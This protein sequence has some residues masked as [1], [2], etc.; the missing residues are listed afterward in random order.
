MHH[1]GRFEIQTLMQV[2]AVHGVQG[3]DWETRRASVRV[4][5]GGSEPW[6]MGKC[7]QA[8]V[9]RRRYGGSWFGPWAFR[10]DYVFPPLGPE[11]GPDIVPT[12]NRGCKFLQI[13]PL[14]REEHG[15]SPNAWVHLVTGPSNR[16]LG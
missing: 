1:V 8:G 2:L 6:L 4:M 13:I 3:P 16:V 10:P 14:H 5:S 7:E 12:A 9:Y 15:R 11:F